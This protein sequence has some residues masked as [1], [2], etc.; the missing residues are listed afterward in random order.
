MVVVGT[1]ETG[2]YSRQQSWQ[3]RPLSGVRQ[4]RRHSRMTH[5]ERR[6]CIRNDAVCT[7]CCGNCCSG[8]YVQDDDEDDDGEGGGRWMTRIQ[9]CC[10]RSYY[11][12][13]WDQ[14]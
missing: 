12:R 9:R 3:P 7:C 1:G 5:W 13:Y 14:E 4:Q 11:H 6:D 2:S 8:H 10:C